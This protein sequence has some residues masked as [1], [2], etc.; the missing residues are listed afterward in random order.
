MS[1]KRTRY[2]GVLNI[3]RF[4]PYFFIMSFVAGLVL[5]ASMF[6]SSGWFSTLLGLCLVGLTYSLV[7]SL[8]I[9]H[10]IYDLSHIYRIPWVRD[11]ATDRKSTWLNINAGFDEITPTL[12]N[13]FPH[14]RLRTMDFYDPLKHTE[15]SIARARSIYPPPGETEKISCHSLPTEDVSV[16]RII[17][18]FSLHEIRGRSERVTMLRELH[19]VLD[20]EGEIYITE[21][22]RDMQ[23]FA[24]YSLGAFH[25]HTRKE[26]LNNFRASKLMVKDEMKTTPFVTTFILTK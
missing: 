9:S 6:L 25:F 10:W 14:V 26:W 12:R 1:M 24:A 21:H 18:M 22:L 8:A 2:Q 3:V 23:N 15:P 20:D 5:M 16:D 11:T 4:N 19:R 13:K 17:A 7:V